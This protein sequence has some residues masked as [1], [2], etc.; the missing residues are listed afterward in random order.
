MLPSVV[1]GFGIG[2]N[3]IMGGFIICAFH[4]FVIKSQRGI[5]GSCNSHGEIITLYNEE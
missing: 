4:V 5:S 1:M 2:E 3:H